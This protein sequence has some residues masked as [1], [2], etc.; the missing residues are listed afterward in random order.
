MS[1]RAAK[2]P[3]W[4]TPAVRLAL[5]LVAL[6]IVASYGLPKIIA[7]ASAGTEARPCPPP[8]RG[9]RARRL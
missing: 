7:G 4:A 8:A 6:A 3:W 9:T 5:L 1:Q 2:P